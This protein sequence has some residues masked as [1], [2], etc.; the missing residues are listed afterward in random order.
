MQ[1]SL[2]PIADRMLFDR[3]RGR[4][5]RGVRLL[6]VGLL[7]F[8]LAAC[9]TKGDIRD[10]GAD[11]R[12]QNQDQAELIRGLRVEQ[13]VL[14]DSIRALKAGQTDLRGTLLNRIASLQ[15]EIQTLRELTGMSQAELAAMRDQ[16]ASQPAR[17]PAVGSGV[18]G[19]ASDLYNDAMDQF[20]R[21]SYTAARLGFQGLVE[22]F[23]THPLAPEARFM[24]GE[25]LVEQGDSEAAI[26]AFLRVPEFHPEA[27]RVPEALY[28]VG[29]L[30]YE[31][32]EESLAIGY[33]ERVVNT[34]PESG[35]ADL[36][37]QLLDEIG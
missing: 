16:L 3:S 11:I 1:N 37:Q 8:A 32:G 27:D 12:A 30:Y 2:H 24:I 34:W 10:L 25:I 6:A 29:R 28:R 18:T 7:A 21:G 36:A 13:Q 22:D 17:G 31:D 9:A 4:L 33:L 26:E 19:A 35:V 5:G 20:R 15:T 23:P 14:Q